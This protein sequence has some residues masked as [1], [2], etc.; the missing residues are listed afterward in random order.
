MVDISSE[1]P[2]LMLQAI[3]AAT[4]N[5][6][7]ED[8][9]PNNRAE[10]NSPSNVDI[11]LY[12]QQY[13]QDERSWN[14]NWEVAT[15]LAIRVPINAN[16]TKVFVPPLALNCR[17][18][19]HDNTQSVQ[20][21]LCPVAV[22]VSVSQNDETNEGITLPDSVGAWSGIVFMESNFPQ[23]N[24][25]DVCDRWGE[26]EMRSGISG[27]GLLEQVI[28]CPPNEATARR[29]PAFEEEKTSSLFRIT[30]YSQRAMTFFHSGISACFRQ[31]R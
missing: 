27:E 6:N 20:V 14:V 16:Q 15:S 26:Y 7:P 12:V 2:M 19:L 17:L 3:S 13:S 21:G 24:L 28:P 4:I 25:R 29:D 9:L 23:P 11:T 22:K 18:P 8:I 31:F 30:S 1:T 5:W 10:I